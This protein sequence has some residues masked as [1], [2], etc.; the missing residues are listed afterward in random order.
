[1]KFTVQNRYSDSN[2][3]DK[4]GRWARI[5]YANNFQIAWIS[6]VWIE[7]KFFYSVNDYFPSQHSDNPCYSIVIDKDL[8][9]VVQEVKNRFAYFV[10]NAIAK[11]TSEYR[12]S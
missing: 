1:M 11:T 4:H 8:E 7:T 3:P 2:Q 10:N 12:I 9:E 5:V 6:K